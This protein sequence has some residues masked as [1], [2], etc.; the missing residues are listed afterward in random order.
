MRKTFSYFHGQHNKDIF[1]LF[2][3]RDRFYYLFLLLIFITY[4]YYLFLLL[5]L[6]QIRNNRKKFFFL[7][8]KIFLFV[9]RVKMENY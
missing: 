4:F 7:L 6:D 9:R 1:P 5:I 3:T 2:V 8:E